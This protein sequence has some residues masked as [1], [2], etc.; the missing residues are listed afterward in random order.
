VLLQ[1]VVLVKQNAVCSKQQQVVLIK[2]GQ[3]HTTAFLG[4]LFTEDVNALII[5]R[6]F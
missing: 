4:Y 5:I 2:Q 3:M 6:L 1:N